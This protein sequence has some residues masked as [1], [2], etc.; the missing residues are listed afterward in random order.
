MSTDA[1]GQK[2]PT[3]LSPNAAAPK[4]RAS[5]QPTP[6]GQEAERLDLSYT[7]ASGRAFHLSLQRSTS[8]QPAT[9]DRTGNLP[10]NA[11]PAAQADGA[12]GLDAALRDTAVA[13]DGFRRLLDAMLRVQDGPYASRVAPA[14]PA[15]TNVLEV[16]SGAQTLTI[17]M[18]VV[19]PE[20]WSVEN[21]AGRLRDFAVALYGGGDRSAHREKMM[22]GM[23]EGYRQAQEAFG[24]TLP[25][26]ARQTVDRAKEMLTEW[27]GQGGAGTAAAAA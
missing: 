23:E 19:D 16:S 1:I 24:G 22:A 13:V 18:D 5:K 15:M 25:E 9:Y 8:P 26:I 4:A 11:R 14:A 3:A 2:L 10:G 6:P 21:T 17:R 20:Y 27:A 12:A 7:D